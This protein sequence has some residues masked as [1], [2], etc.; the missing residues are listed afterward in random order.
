MVIYSKSA[1]ETAQ[2]WAREAVK[3]GEWCLDWD[4]AM[5]MLKIAYG[6]ATIT[7]YELRY[8]VMKGEG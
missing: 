7:E 3:D 5:T 6:Y 1:F 8:E 2:K 4:C